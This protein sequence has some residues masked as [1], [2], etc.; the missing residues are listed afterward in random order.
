[1]E[2]VDTF[3]FRSRPNADSAADTSAGGDSGAVRSGHTTS[4]DAD[5]TADATNGDGAWPW[6]GGRCWWSWYNDNNSVI[7]FAIRSVAAGDDGDTGAD[8]TKLL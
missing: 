8:V 6:S 3:W 2:E 7:V 5:L 4:I 1:M